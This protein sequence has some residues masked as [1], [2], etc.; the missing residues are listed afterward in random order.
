MD[1]LE[2]K[3]AGPAES[4]SVC[5]R[6]HCMGVEFLQLV[7]IRGQWPFGSGTEQPRSNAGSTR[8]GNHLLDPAEV[9]SNASEKMLENNGHFLQAK[10]TAEQRAVEIVRLQDVVATH[11]KENNDLKV[12]VKMLKAVIPLG[13]YYPLSNLGTSQQG[14]HPRSV[15]TAA[16]SPNGPGRSSSMPAWRS[17]IL[18]KDILM[19]KCGH[20]HKELNDNS[21]TS[22]TYLEN[23]DGVPVSEE[24]IME[25]SRKACM[26]WRTLDED[27]MALQTFSQISMKAWEYFSAIML[28]DKSFKFLLLC[29]DGEWKLREWSMQSYPS[30]HHNRFNKDADDASSEGKSVL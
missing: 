4:V 8:Y 10:L 21:K 13:V 22:H 23:I 29:K 15:M 5:F 17:L 11:A 19:G 1:S 27:G 24:Q 30:W 28:T 3:K 6:G 14:Q 25:M 7:Y 9:V 18:S 16:Q 2:R 20:P 26:L 12:E